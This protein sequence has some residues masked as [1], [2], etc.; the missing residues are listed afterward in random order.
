MKL[1]VYKVEFQNGVLAHLAVSGIVDLI[2]IAC[3]MQ[4]S[5]GE[6]TKVELIG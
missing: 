3:Y 6:V 5:L 1:I 2:K 4:Q